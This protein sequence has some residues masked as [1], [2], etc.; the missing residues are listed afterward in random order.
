MS[1]DNKSQKII[2]S[3][4]VIKSIAYKVLEKNPQDIIDYKKGVEGALDRLVGK[5]FKE[6]EGKADPVIIRM[7]LKEILK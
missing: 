2:T 1:K 5:V 6:S 7:M 3:K 4:K